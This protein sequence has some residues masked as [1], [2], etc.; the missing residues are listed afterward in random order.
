MN[1]IPS[2]S[3]KYC[4]LESQC[5]LALGR[6]MSS[7]AIGKVHINHDWC[8]GIIEQHLWLWHNYGNVSARSL[9]INVQC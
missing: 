7:L 6:V 2:A 9:Q 1:A 4:S 3:T 5:E 8:H